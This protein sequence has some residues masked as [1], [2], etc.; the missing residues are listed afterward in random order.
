M[1]TGI[2]KALLSPPWSNPRLHTP[3]CTHRTEASWES[4]RMACSP[5]L[6]GKAACSPHLPG[7]GVGVTLIGFQLALLSSKNNKDGTLYQWGHA[8]KSRSGDKLC[9]A[10]WTHPTTC[11]AGK[12][13]SAGKQNGEWGKAR[14]WGGLLW[15]AGW[16]KCSIVSLWLCVGKQQSS[17]DP[18]SG[19]LKCPSAHS[20]NCCPSSLRRLQAVY[21]L[22]KGESACQ[23]I[24]ILWSQTKPY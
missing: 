1:G 13:S 21:F 8:L 11:W 19:E 9:T 17:R 14:W 2:S 5:Q 15:E 12:F 18:L 20:I 4:P 23:L 10:L 24:C 16:N 6:Q 7:V 3:H 22:R